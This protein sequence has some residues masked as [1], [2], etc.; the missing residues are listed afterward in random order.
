MSGARCERCGAAGPDATGLCKPCRI[1]EEH[2]PD[3]RRAY[4]SNLG[5]KGAQA[6]HANRRKAGI[7]PDELPPLRTPKDAERW[8]E[9]VARAVAE[10]RLSH[11]EGKAIASI[12]RGFLKAHSDGTTSDRIAALEEMFATL[13]GPRKVG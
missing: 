2:G 4:Y 11:S 9:I 5:T 6:F 12:L 10:R 8:S 13:K 7:E 1:G 3:A